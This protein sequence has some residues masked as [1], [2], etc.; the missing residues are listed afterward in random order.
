MRPL[1]IAGYYGFDNLGDE[2]ILAAVLRGLAERLPEARPVVLSGAPAETTRQHGVAAIDRGDLSAVTALAADAGLIVLGGGG[3]LQD[4]WPA[5][6]AHCLEPGGGGLPFYLR[7]PLLAAAA[8]RP[9]SLLALGVGPLGT[10]E[11]RLLAGAAFELATTA[12][13]RDPGSL[14]LFR[15]LGLSSPEPLLGADP[16]V[17]LEPSSSDR[18]VALLAELGLSAEEPLLGIAPRPWRF[19]VE[20]ERWEWEVALAIEVHL[21]SHAGTALLLPFQ[22]APGAEAE[23]DLAVCDRLAGRIPL[24]GR[25]RVVPHH[26][27]PALAM[28]L[29]TRCD[30]VLAMRYHAALF[31]L[32]AGV[33]TV[34]LAYDPKVAGLLSEARLDDLALPPREWT[35]SAVS[36]C[37]EKCAAPAIRRRLPGL[38]DAWRSRASAALDLAARSWDVPCSRSRSATVL[39]RLGLALAPRVGPAGPG[40]GSA[41]TGAPAGPRPGSDEPDTATRVVA[42]FLSAASSNASEPLALVLSGTRCDESNGQR[43][44]RLARELH[45]GGATVVFSYFRWPQESPAPDA[46]FGDGFLALP[47]DALL[48]EPATLAEVRSPARRVVLVEFPY[49]P[50]FEL[51][52]LLRARGWAVLYD[53]LDDWSAF[54][55]VGEAPWFD[56]EFERWLLANADEVTAVSPGLAQRHQ[57]LVTRSVRVVGNAAREDLTRDRTTLATARGEVTVGYFGYLSPAW[58]DWD[59]IGELA[60]RR[61]TWSF[62]IAGYG[63]PA[64]LALPPNVRLLGRQPSTTLGSLATGWDVGIVPFRQGAVAEAADPIKVYEYL[65]LGLPVVTCGAPPPPGTERFVRWATGVEAAL[66]ALGGFHE[67]G[68]A[69][70]RRR[71]AGTLSWG[72]RVKALLAAAEDAWTR[73]DSA[74]H[75]GTELWR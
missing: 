2:A 63:E 67:M 11:G 19:G 40:G 57:G 35:S 9:L 18:A 64:G 47:L 30:A 31:A 4:Y 71:L 1:L 22:H 41:P 53:V 43:P 72:S 42:S 39:S 13:V 10:D 34:A 61:P 15:Q 62:Q 68:D 55:R 29:L 3:L 37:L 50:L 38:A 66:A 36:A 17:L 65:A 46:P 33:P 45:R 23:D 58:F 44:C 52:C 5:P 12:S 32:A 49:P 26:L 28:A 70:E 56:A 27:T 73:I 6:L 60:R 8:E 48:R 16:A 51:I 21:R 74:S 24:P 20:Q 59:L 7:F 75:D 69:A 25:V 54:H 14:A